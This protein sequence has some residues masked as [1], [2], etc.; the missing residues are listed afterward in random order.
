LWIL[1]VLGLAVA[2]ILLVRFI[3]KKRSADSTANLPQSVPMTT[4]KS[5]VP[6][7]AGPPDDIAVPPE[8]SPSVA[9]NPVQATALSGHARASATQAQ[10]DLHNRWNRLLMGKPTSQDLVRFLQSLDVPEIL[11]LMEDLCRADTAAATK[12]IENAFVPVLKLKWSDSGADWQAQVPYDLLA[13]LAAD[14]ARPSLFR[15]VLLDILERGSRHVFSEV[16]SV[17]PRVASG[18]AHIAGDKNDAVDV[19]LYAIGDLGLLCQQ[20]GASQSPHADALLR[21]AGDITDAPAVR[22]RAMQSLALIGDL[23]LLPLLEGICTEYSSETDASLARS[24]VVA[25]AD[26]ARERGATALK[27]MTHVLENTSDS[28]VL[29]SSLYAISLLNDSAFVE[30]M[31]AVMTKTAQFPR[32]PLVANSLHAAL[33]RH[34]AA[35]IAALNSDDETLVLAGIRAAALVALPPARPRLE[36]LLRARAPGDAAVIEAALMQSENIQTYDELLAQI[37]KEKQD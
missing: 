9:L 31:P 29:A 17:L 5:N 18:L 22:G 28:R 21:L 26:I 16:P 2:S 3:Q 11:D 35:I 14:T 34:P 8:P 1:C 25:L 24:A 20:Q 13:H 6:L 4:G 37:E 19:R 10:R 36:A 12:V 15:K 33:S 23:R 30:A 7:L 32:D 27:P